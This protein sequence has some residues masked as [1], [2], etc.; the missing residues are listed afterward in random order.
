M[1]VNPLCKESNPFNGQCTGCYQGYTLS[2]GECV[3]GFDRDPNCK[4]FNG[5]TCV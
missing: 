3:V 1:G 5:D 2:N 4:R